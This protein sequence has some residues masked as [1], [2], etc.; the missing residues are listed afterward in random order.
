[1]NSSL[2]F[3]LKKV[4]C[5]HMVSMKDLFTYAR[6]CLLADGKPQPIQLM[7]CSSIEVMMVV[8]VHPIDLCCALYHISK[9]VLVC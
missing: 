6:A 3:F 9:V 2:V 1:M 5:A 4:W 8:H 7:T